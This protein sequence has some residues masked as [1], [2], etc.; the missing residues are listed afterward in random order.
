MCIKNFFLCGYTQ[1]LAKEIVKYDGV[2]F[3]SRMEGIPIALTDALLCNR[4]AIVTPVGGMP[5]FIIDGENGFVADNVS[6]EAI[7]E[8]LERAWQRRE[9][10]KGLSKNAGKKIRELVTE[11]PQQQ[12]IDEINNIIK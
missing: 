10:W 11:F 1:D 7:D 4:M 5:E 3:P 2:I 9:E 8:C 12:C 6:T